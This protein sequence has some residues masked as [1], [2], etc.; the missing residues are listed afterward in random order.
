MRLLLL[1]LLLATALSI[2]PVPPTLAQTAP[3]KA[4]ADALADPAV[5]AWIASQQAAPPAA[6]PTNTSSASTVAA[7]LDEAE[8]RA[9]AKLVALKT[10]LTIFP[11]ELE[12]ALTIWSL[13]MGPEK[14]LGLVVSL[15]GF[16]GFAY[17]AER[18]FWYSTR[19]LRNRVVTN[20]ALRTPRLKIREVGLRIVYY[21]AQVS[22]FAIAGFGSFLAFTWEP[23]TRLL[24][25]SY[26]TALLAVLL[27]HI[28]SYLF[29]C[30]LSA[31]LRLVPLT[32]DAARRLHLVL[33][34][35]AGVN[36]VSIMTIGALHH[37]G[38]FAQSF[39]LLLDSTVLL[40]ALS[41][42]AGMM[43]MAGPIGRMLVAEQAGEARR[44]RQILARFWP[45]LGM[46]LVLAHAGLVIMGARPLGNT[47]L[48]LAVWPLADITLR[49]MVFR[50]ASTDQPDHPT[51]QSIYVPVLQR[52]VRL[53]LAAAMAL[54]LGANWGVDILNSGAQ[55]SGAFRLLDVAV[56]VLV[57]LLMA[58][59]I[60][61][62]LRITI[63]AKL[64]ETLPAGGEQATE[65]EGEGGVAGP[66][67]RL[68][69]LLPLIRK[70]LAAMVLV[71]T[72]LTALSALGVDIG[73]LLAGAGVA[74]IAIGF[75]A[76]ALVKDIVS[77]IFFLID[78]AFRVG[79][80]VEIGTLRGTVEAISIRSLKLRHHLGQV[81]VMPFGEMRSLTNY[82]RDWVMV[83][84]EF[85][86]PFETDMRLVKKIV[87]RI[88][89]EML[90]SPEHG[91]TFLQPLK[92][93]G[94][95]RVEEF[96]MVIGVKFMCK[97]G[98]QWVL[99]R[100]IYHK[101]LE[102]FEA[103]G[104]HLARRDVVVRVSRDASPEE[105]EEAIVAAAQPAIEQAM[106]APGKPAPA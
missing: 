50:L 100:E 96:N 88:G 39:S 34:T 98:E 95:R 63:D 62:S 49:H 9:K 72:L 1:F 89:Q 26:L 94:V 41:L 27:T 73:P 90:D 21:S 29:I 56:D 3:P 10:S 68:H 19:D 60:W 45:I 85:R 8:D 30:P 17:V 37:L 58:D 64:A 84:L 93:Q 67:A 18:L 54:M 57:I 4:L 15:I 24:V 86:M 74:G 55:G 40:L 31:K 47:L 76:Q 44:S 38:F 105:M 61:T 33:K 91:H 42:C 79:E 81:H 5:Q 97:P 6:A 43:A 20:A 53:L 101:L 106:P 65:N 36:A 48:L 69:T 13:E 102:A 80:Y 87:K 70:T 71:I 83:K 99:R 52:L 7:T 25:L 32:D 78:D 77:G 104:L 66:H 12:T 35:I 46:I 14:S 82:S 28:V 59:L 11:S 51:T 75:G 16:L 92:S 22:V 2:L 103:A 23:I